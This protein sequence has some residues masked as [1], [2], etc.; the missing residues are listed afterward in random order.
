MRVDRAVRQLLMLTRR[1]VPLPLTHLR[2]P[3]FASEGFAP[4]PLNQGRLQAVQALRIALRASK[5]LS[6]PLNRLV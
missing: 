6:N 3:Y 4:A 5:V 2:R 1:L